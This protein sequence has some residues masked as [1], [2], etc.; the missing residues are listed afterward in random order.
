MEGV[1]QLVRL[2]SSSHDCECSRDLQTKLHP[3][4]LK[5]ADV[6]GRSGRKV[7]TTCSPKHFE[8]MIELGASEV[9]DYVC[10]NFSHPN[11]SPHLSN[12]FRSF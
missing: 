5:P 4:L 2:Q 12:H 11:N 3:S 1:Q 7:I 8:L 10:L 6:I 9:Y